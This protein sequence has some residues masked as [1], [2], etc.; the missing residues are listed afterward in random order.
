MQDNRKV[1]TL[2]SNF[3]FLNTSNKAE[4]VIQMSDNKQETKF[5]VRNPTLVSTELKLLSRCTPSLHGT[6]V[7]LAS[8]VAT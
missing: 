3:P 5:I 7:F 1:E 8:S 4:M 6:S 2:G